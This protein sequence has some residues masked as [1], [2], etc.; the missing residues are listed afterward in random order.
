ME[1]EAR[2]YLERRVSRPLC[3]TEN[4]HLKRGKENMNV[5]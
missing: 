2:G 5:D 1:P 4:R 3:K